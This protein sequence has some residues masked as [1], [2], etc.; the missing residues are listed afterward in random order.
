MVYTQEY[1]NGKVYAYGFDP[2]EWNDSTWNFYI[3][4]PKTFEADEVLYARRLPLRLRYD[5]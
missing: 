3:M 1:C 2:T 5:L 4:D